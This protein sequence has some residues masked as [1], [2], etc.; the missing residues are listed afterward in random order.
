MKISKFWREGREW[1]R[2]FRDDPQ[3]FL[4]RLS[5]ISPELG[6]RS[7]SYASELLNGP[8]LGMGIEVDELSEERFG[9]RILPRRRNRWSQ[10]QV[11]VGPLITVAE[12]MV[13]SVWQRHWGGPMGGIELSHVTMSLDSGLILPV[14]LRF[15]M[16]EAERE[17][18]I[19]EAFNKNHSQ[20]IHS[21]VL[22]RHD[23]VRIG[24]IQLTVVLTVAPRLTGSFPVSRTNL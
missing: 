4:S 6:R 5:E 17:A 9:L 13:R 22:F 19:K 24:E 12:F 18:A 2:E 11:S 3:Q 8:I 10:G 1:V 16:R 7:L 20:L 23:G 14:C 21:V 15:E